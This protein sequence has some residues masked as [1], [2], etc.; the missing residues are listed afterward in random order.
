MV[1]NDRPLAEL[2]P[3]PENPRIIDDEAVAVVARSIAEFGFVVPLLVAPDGEVVC[4][5]TRLRAA[6]QLGLAVVPCA[7]TDG[8]T[9]D[10]I[11]AFRVVENRT[12]DLAGAWD[13]DA[14]APLVVDLGLDGWFNADDL[15]RPDGFDDV[16]MPPPPP[17]HE[18]AVVVD[19]YDEPRDILVSLVVRC[20]R[21]DWESTRA[22]V[23][24]AAGRFIE[25][26]V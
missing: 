7:S 5:H 14:L 23:Q 13:A 20:R 12:H 4:G 2:R 21:A 1:V 19:D 18:A 9:P 3:A 16:P 26:W 10:Q 25:E 24:A 15:P 11:R 8:M 22:T 17:E 6:Q